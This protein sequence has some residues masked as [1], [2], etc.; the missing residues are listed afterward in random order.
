[1]SE[2]REEIQSLVTKSTTKKKGASQGRQKK[3]TAR[4]AASTRLTHLPLELLLDQLPGGVVSIDGQG[5]IQHMNLEARALLGKPSTDVRLEDWPQTFGLYQEDNALFPNDRLPPL[6]AL[7]GE[8]GHFEEMILRRNGAE[9][10]SWIL[11][12][13]RPVDG[14]NGVPGGATAFIREIT[15][16]KQTELARERYARRIETFYR[17]TRVLAA[18][19][20][21]IHQITRSV[22]VLASEVLGDLCSITLLNRDGQ[23]M[24]ISAAHDTDP[25][26]RALFEQGVAASQDYPADRGLSGSVLRSGEP[27]LRPSLSRQQLIENASPGF[28]PFLQQVNLS[29]ALIVPMI[30]RS[31]IIGTINMFRHA[32]DDPYD[33]SDQSFL[34]EIAYRTALAIEHTILIESLR[35]EIAANATVTE[36]LDASQ[37]RFRTIFESTALGVKV[38]DLVGTILDTNAAFQEMMGYHKEEL[39]GRNL[40]DFVHPDEV[41]RARSLFNDMKTTGVQD[42]RFEHR[43]LHKDGSTVWVKASFSGVRHG[44]AGLMFVFGIT[45]DVTEQ[46]KIEA[47]MSE[48]QKRLQTSAELERLRVARELHDGPMQELYSAMYRLKQ[49]AAKVAPELASNLE[50][51]NADIQRVLQDLR[52]TAK[53]LRPPAISNFGLEK[54]IRSHAEDFQQQYPDLKLH[55]DL[56]QDRQLLPEDTRL[57]LFRVYQQ[58]M[59]NIAQHAR[60]TE[61]WVH[62]AFDA[63]EIKLEIMDN[64][65]GFTVPPTWISLVRE[66]H[67]GLAG[68]AERMI[69]I[70]GSLLVESRFPERTL[71]RAAIPV[72]DAFMHIGAEEPTPIIKRARDLI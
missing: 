40:F 2:L 65:S 20:M 31:G 36:A 62:F 29:S 70:G 58:S 64:G 6:R 32:P 27:L 41:E 22:A 38:L 7:R 50:D 8:E 45:E 16:R 66:G 52:A 18:G 72:H 54:A 28:L 1:M 12:T 5:R 63:E 26:A 49:L 69:G 51:V 35:S 47:E 42:F 71:V 30:G 19:D 13:A 21:D 10:Q 57:A 60:A 48:M 67:Y 34:M 44:D 37:E 24:S 56:A 46:K 3:T 61:V 43:V 11:M 14:A 68:A 39:L 55:L 9:K 23:R 53:E 15:E 17:L 33:A 25:V 4:A 59:G